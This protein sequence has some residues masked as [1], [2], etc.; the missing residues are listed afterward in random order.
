MREA[1]IRFEART[2]LVVAFVLL[3]ASCSGSDSGTTGA[4]QAQILAPIVEATEPVPD[5]PGPIVGTSSSAMGTPHLDGAGN[6]VT[7]H[8][9]SEWPSALDPLDPFGNADLQLFGT[10][11][12]NAGASLVAIDVEV[13]ASVDQGVE[14]Q[15]FRSRFAP[16]ESVD[17]ELPGPDADPRE[18]M[19]FDPVVSPSFVWPAAGE[20]ARGWQGLA[21]EI[22]AAAPGAALYTDISTAPDT[23]GERTLVRWELTGDDSAMP[24]AVTTPRGEASSFASAGL[25]DWNITV[26]GWSWVP[27][28]NDATSAVGTRFVPPLDG[29][30]LG[31]V[32]LEWCSSG[33]SGPPTFGLQIDGWNLLPQFLRG[34]PW[35]PGYSEPE[36]GVD[37]CSAGWL[38]FEVPIGA[39]PTAVFVVDPIDRSAP[40]TSWDLVD[41]E[42]AP[43]AL[44]NAFDGAVTLADAEAECGWSNQW[45]FETQALAGA[46]FELPQVLDARTAVAVDDSASRVEAYIA[47]AE[48]G[49]SDVPVPPENTTVVQLIIEN[50]AGGSFE[51]GA[52]DDSLTQ[53]QYAS[54][55]VLTAEGVVAILDG[56]EVDLVQ[57]ND[58]LLCGAIASRGSIPFDA[59]FALAR[60]QE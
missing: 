14:E 50:A 32:A 10:S 44:P 36:I 38:P 6:T 52:Y 26:L 40:R 23:F 11:S 15:F 46:N 13:C 9:F 53:P 47:V 2:A 57:V 27:D 20:C 4:D 29:T 12:L 16:L 34:G 25:A 7:V 51:L 35:G 3:V 33:T 58:D 8:G 30:R 49:P 31:A 37:G 54:V 18:A 1:P 19:V 59:E 41:G 28:A 39:A 42:I 43:P 24:P 55:R 56:I 5:E 17:S 45:R 22:E 48:L 60:W 21:W